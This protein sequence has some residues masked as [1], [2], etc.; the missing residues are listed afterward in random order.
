VRPAALALLL[1]VAS[2]AA[3]Q[4]A[5]TIANP[6]AEPRDDALVVVPAAGI[7]ESADWS[8]TIDGTRYP[9]QRVER[10]DGSATIVFTTDLDAHGRVRAELVP[11]AVEASP[12]VAAVLNVQTGSHLAGEHFVGGTYKQLDHLDVP[13]EH[14]IHDNLIAFE[15]PGWESDRVAYR[16]YLDER[17]VTDIFGKKRPAPILGTI[18]MGGDDY[19][20]DADWGMDVF[21]VDQSLGVGGLGTIRNGMAEQIGPATITATVEENGPVVAAVRVEDKG[22]QG[23]SGPVDLTA[24]YSIAAG[25]RVTRVEASL[26]D[27]ATPLVAGLTHHEGV[28]VV[29]APPTAERWGYVATYGKQSLAGDRLG[30]VLFY[31]GGEGVTTHDD[32]RSLYIRFADPRHV[33]YAFAAAWEQ[34]PAAPKAQGAFRRW[35]AQ[36]AAELAHPVIAAVEP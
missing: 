33:R 2:P 22:W 31:P 36:Q 13:P 5:V 11:E 34:E 17:N 16:L 10:P 35:I 8:V 9:A 23:A 6:S 14:L 12:R 25:S 20:A 27:P 4:T 24:R 28:A 29:A 32:G 3:A 30:I 1:T 7:G 18:G 19:H 26:S 21:Q 15:G